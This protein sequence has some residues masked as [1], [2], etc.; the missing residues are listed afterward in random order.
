MLL[1]RLRTRKDKKIKSG[2]TQ[3]GNKNEVCSRE[4]KRSAIKERDRLLQSP[5]ST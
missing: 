1:E 3:N 5:A 2:I 4:K